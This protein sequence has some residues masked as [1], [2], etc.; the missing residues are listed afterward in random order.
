MRVL[1]INLRF[2]NEADGPNNWPFR[3]EMV[4]QVINRFSPHILGTQEGFRSQ[5]EDLAELI[6]RYCLRDIH[7][8]WDPGRMY[9]CIFYNPQEISIKESGDFWLSETP[10]I[11]GSLSWGSSHPKLATYAHCEVL[12]TGKKFL[13]CDAHLD[14]VSAEARKRGALVLLEQLET[15]NKSELSL[16]V[17][18]DFNGP[19]SSPEHGILTGEQTFQGKTGKLRD[20]WHI[21]GYPEEEAETYHNFEGIGRSGR[22]DWILVSREVAV[23]EATIIRDSFNGRY[24]S[25]HFPVGAKLRL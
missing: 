13:F 8:Y 17:V 19:P 2:E 1:T 23:E 22:I 7:R 3:K 11:H 15:I 14:N 12:E 10:H 16:I 25:D 9:P 21:M 18:G 24:P 6:P 4:A 20:V 5:A